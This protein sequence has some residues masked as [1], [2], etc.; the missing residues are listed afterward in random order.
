MISMATAATITAIMAVVS[1]GVAVYGQLQQS[2]MMDQQAEAEAKAKDLQAMAAM[3]QMRIQ[4]AKMEKDKARMTS[5]QV[6][7]GAGA[8]VQ[9]GLEDDS[10]YALM[11]ETKG[12]WDEDISAL[13]NS[14]M[15]TAGALGY[16]AAGYRSSATG[17][18]YFKAAATGLNGLSTGMSYGYKAGWFGEA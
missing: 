4:K 7:A 8:G 16:S 18:D 15:A 3:D 9:T 17:P 12:L 1:A 5:S 2:A 13:E 6:V 11:E 14:G 10:L